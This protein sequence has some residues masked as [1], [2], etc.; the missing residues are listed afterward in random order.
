MSRIWFLYVF[1]IC[2]YVAPFKIWRKDEWGE[3][4]PSPLITFSQSTCPIEFEIVQLVQVFAPKE[5]MPQVLAEVLKQPIFGERHLS[6]YICIYNFLFVC[7]P[8]TGLKY[9]VLG[10]VVGK[11]SVIH[12]VNYIRMEKR[13][14]KPKPGNWNY[15]WNWRGVVN[16]SKR[17]S[18][19]VRSKV[20]QGKWFRK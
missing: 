9:K 3:T 1:D 4:S 11:G 15:L 7:V 18:H 20:S 17:I 19:K 6:S 14:K 16:K 8:F 5:K 13:S 10:P 2:W 12:W